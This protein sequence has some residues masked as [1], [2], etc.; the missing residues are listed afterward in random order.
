MGWTQRLLCA[1]LCVQ[2]AASPVWAI[3][4]LED[5]EWRRGVAGRC[6]RAEVVFEI[7]LGPLPGAD[8]SRA[9]EIERLEQQKQL[10]GL[11]DYNTT[12]SHNDCTSGDGVLKES[13]LNR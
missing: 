4:S 8:W 13:E 3:L 11:G 12:S 7:M 1:Q 5:N 10:K 9:S 2:C 6:V